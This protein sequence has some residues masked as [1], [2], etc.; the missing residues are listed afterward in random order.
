MGQDDWVTPEP[1]APLPAPSARSILIT[2]L[3][4]LVYPQDDPVWTATLLTVMRGLGVEDHAARQAIARSTAA[5]WIQSQRQGRAVRW[6][7]AEH[8]REVIEDGIRRSAAFLDES[9]QWD[10]RWLTLLVSVPQ[11]QRTVVSM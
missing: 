5:G 7:V 1:F 11:E 4:D 6:Q 10:G 8:G 9:A 2:V 3:G